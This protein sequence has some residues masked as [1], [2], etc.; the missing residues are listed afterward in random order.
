MSL[1]RMTDDNGKPYWV[2]SAYRRDEYVM[3][4]GQL[5]YLRGSI[6]ERETFAEQQE[7]REL[8]WR[9][10]V[11]LT[12]EEHAGK[13]LITLV[14]DTANWAIVVELVQ[15]KLVA[16]EPVA[17]ELAFALVARYDAQRDIKVV[18]E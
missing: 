5:S 1:K 11:E 4:A 10:W 17:P 13:T 15:G 7:D 8:T 14:H 6:G 2:R 16:V 3:P 12:R 18:A 9:D